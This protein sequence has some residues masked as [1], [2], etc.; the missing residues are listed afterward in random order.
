MIKL[1]DRKIKR[2]VKK[3]HNQCERT[4]AC[5]QCDEKGRDC[6]I[7]RG[8]KIHNWWRKRNVF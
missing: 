4:P 2:I 3:L 7:E 1:T 8:V 5:Y 6:P